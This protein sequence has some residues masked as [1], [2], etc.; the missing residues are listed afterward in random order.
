MCKFVSEKIKDVSE[1]SDK[2]NTLAEIEDVID[3]SCTVIFIDAKTK[4][5]AYA[6]FQVLND[7]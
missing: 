3:R 6:L 1:I 4:R 2:L 5:D 7:N